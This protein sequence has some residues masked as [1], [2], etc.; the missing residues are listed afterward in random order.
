M[1]GR[2]VVRRIVRE[3][4]QTALLFATFLVLLVIELGSIF[5]V[6]A[7]RG[8]PNANIKTGGDALWWSIVSVT[9]VRGL[10]RRVPR[11]HAR[12]AASSGPSS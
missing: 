10:R 9:T 11:M 12:L 8:A 1:G 4:A 3:R 2:R 5:V 6:I 7:E